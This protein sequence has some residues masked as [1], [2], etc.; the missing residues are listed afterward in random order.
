[1]KLFKWF[2]LPVLFAGLFITACKKDNLTLGFEDS[3]QMVASQDQTTAEDLYTD[4][5]DQAD[6]AI[7]TRGAGPDPCPIVT[8][9]PDDGSYPRTITIDF[10]D[11]CVGPKG[12]VRKGKIIVTVTDTITNAGAVRT[13]TF[14]D[15]YIDGVKV[16]GTKTLTNLGFDDEG[17]VAFNRTVTGGKLTFPNGD[18]ATW[19]SDFTLTQVEGGNTPTY[20]DNVFE[21]TGHS[22]GVNRHGKSYST[23]ILEPVVRKKLCPWAVAGVLSLTIEDK[24]VTIDYGDGECDNKAILTAPDGSEHIIKIKKWW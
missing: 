2:A 23:E 18:V 5:E 11:G 6:W 7:E 8:I 9:D 4:V 12:R 21:I 20:L 14:E 13:T 3:E 24:T 10:G 1:M 17:N 15:F 22:S 19:E 16:E